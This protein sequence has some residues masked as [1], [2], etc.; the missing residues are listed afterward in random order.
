MQFPSCTDEEAISVA[1]LE[2]HY[3]VTVHETVHYTPEKKEPSH[4]PVALSDLQDSDRVGL[5][6]QFDAECTYVCSYASNI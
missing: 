3:S 4:L 1:C 6:E 5:T 2:L